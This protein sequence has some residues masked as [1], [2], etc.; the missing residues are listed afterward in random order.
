MRCKRHQRFAFTDTG[1]K[2]AALRRKQEKERAALPLFAE[3]IA[4]RQPR[5]DD[6]MQARAKAWEDQEGRDR[7]RRAHD[8]RAARATLA[9]MSLKERRVLRRAWDC[10]PYPADPANL[11]GV[12]HSYRMGR[13]RLDDLPFPL[14]RTDTHG[15]R[16]VNFFDK[17]GSTM[18]VTILKARDIASAPT[19]YTPEERLAAYHHL[20]E[21]AT[22]NKDRERAKQDRVL[23]AALYLKLEDTEAHINA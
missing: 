21:A 6:V 9:A 7:A 20:Q 23:S 22:K 5:A 4:E 3:Q 2:R 13:F 19:D 10:A 8:W 17:K 16:H 14:T 12:L 1:R 18:F 15:R 11:S